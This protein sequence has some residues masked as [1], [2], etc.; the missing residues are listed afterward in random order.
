MGRLA[1][2]TADEVIRRL[3]R[4]GFVYDRQAKGAHEIWRNPATHARTMVP[5]HRGDLAEGTVAAIVKQARLSVEEFL[6]F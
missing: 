3:R 4:A 1:G 6:G 5:R 2:F